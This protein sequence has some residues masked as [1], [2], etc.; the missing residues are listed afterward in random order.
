MLGLFLYVWM[1]RLE[2]TQP[3]IGARTDFV[4]TCYV[5]GKIIQQGVPSQLYPESSST[6]YIDSAFPQAAHRIIPTLPT[7]SLPV[8]QYPP[9]GA[10]FFS[11]FANCTP[12]A[13]LLIWQAVSALAL[14]IS[15]SLWM[16]ILRLRAVDAMIL[17]LCFAPIFLMV[18][19]GQQGLVFGVLPLVASSWL[20]QAD[21]P[22]ISGLVSALTYFNPKYCFVA[23]LAA[24]VRCP[25]QW[26]PLVGLF[27]G[28][29]ICIGLETAIS[30][31]SFNS[32]LHSLRLAEAYFFD[33]H[34]AHG[35]YLY[36]SLPPLLVLNAPDAWR[37]AIK[38]MVYIAAAVY[39]VLIA[40]A[41]K[42]LLKSALFTDKETALLPVAFGLY[43]MP[44]VQPHLLYYDL[45]GIILANICLW[46]IGSN[47]GSQ[48]MK[49]LLLTSF[50]VINGYYILIVL[51]PQQAPPLLFA[52]V[53]AALCFEL[54]RETL[55]C[56]QAPDKS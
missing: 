31:T 30:Q 3:D 50:A 56:T 41:C 47:T 54:M 53:L 42:R 51:A 34:L 29:V 26:Q 46:Q 37:I 28:F 45:S 33:P 5:A 18:K 12:E 1:V 55:A 19:I 36:C 49:A 40:V 14:I 32:W 2:L 39:T 10:R 48:R 20:L 27:V 21:H 17:S 22:L 6:T 8:W 9:L 44:V 38:W 25:R 16:R 7:D 24:I 43:A 13:A 4:H 23:G 35:T 15:C 52:S 11:L